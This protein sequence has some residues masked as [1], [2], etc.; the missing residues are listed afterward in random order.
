MGRNDWD[1]ALEINDFSKKNDKGSKR[2]AKEDK[3]WDK[4]MK[5]PKRQQLHSAKE[6]TR[7]RE[8]ISRYMSGSISE[9]EYYDDYEER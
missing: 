4:P 7:E 5:R 2:R 3:H 9:D 1:E 8:L 6:K